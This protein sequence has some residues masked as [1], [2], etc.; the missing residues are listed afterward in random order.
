MLPLFPLELRH[1][2]DPLF[3]P[4]GIGCEGSSARLKHWHQRRCVRWPSQWCSKLEASAGS[5]VDGKLRYPEPK[6]GLGVA[7]CSSPFIVPPPLPVRLPPG[8]P[9]GLPLHPRASLLRIP[10]QSVRQDHLPPPRARGRLRP[11]IIRRTPPI[12]LALVTV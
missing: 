5:I 6:G 9:L 10:R 3:L 8:R 7:A 2:Q 11:H 1:P 4:Q 12:P